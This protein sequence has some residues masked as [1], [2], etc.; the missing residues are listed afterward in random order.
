[1]KTFVVGLDASPRADA[2]LRDAV[3]L[4]S[5]SGARLLL[6]HVVHLPPDPPSDLLALSTEYRER[7]LRKVRR[8][9]D[10]LARTVPDDLLAGVRI[11]IGVPWTEICGVARESRADLIVI[12]SHGYG[13]LDR[14]LGTT[15]A[16]VV[17]HAATPVFVVRPHE[18]E[19]A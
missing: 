4:S 15:A 6:V 19:A 12:G 17:N 9:L 18:N 10:A 1:M 13:T 14:I 16:N 8:E 7:L 2:I 5:T 11:Q 3:S